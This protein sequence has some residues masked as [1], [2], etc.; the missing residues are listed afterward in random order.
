MPLTAGQLHYTFMD[1]SV[2]LLGVV[3]KYRPLD[4][5]GHRFTEDGH[6]FKSWSLAHICYLRILRDILAYCLHITTGQILGTAVGEPIRHAVK[7]FHTFWG[8]QGNCTLVVAILILK[9]HHFVQFAFE[10]GNYINQSSRHC[11]KHALGAPGI[12][13]VLLIYDFKLLENF[14]NIQFT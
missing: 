6:S 2:V 4:L 10:R 12:K 5:E 11:W 8:E 1:S 7:S 13:H 9:R 3:H 14:Y